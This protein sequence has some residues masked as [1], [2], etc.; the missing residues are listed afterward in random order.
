MLI[1]K[2][3]HYELLSIDIPSKKIFKIISN[4]IPNSIFSKLNFSF[5]KKIL[6]K[7]IIN[8][9]CI[10][11]KKKI[12]SIV[13][14]TTVD[15]YSNLKKEVITYL[16]FNPWIILQNL[17]FFV[18]SIKRDSNEI[19]NKD[20]KKYLHLL[21]FIVFKKRFSNL[22]LKKKDKI[23]NFFLKEIIKKNNA[24]IFYLCYERNN[25]KAHNYY[26]RNNYYIY[27]QNEKVFFI[28]KRIL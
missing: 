17:R 6:N 5:F 4:Q 25:F 24:K 26:K 15:N 14:T 27:K 3:D 28:K 1:F 20:K 10:K 18:N 8:I 23:I 7:K 11:R 12:S 9:Y 2:K 19:I 21:H 16:L 13:T 22:T